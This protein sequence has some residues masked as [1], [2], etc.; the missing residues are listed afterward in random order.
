MHGSPVT[1]FTYF[2]HF[3]KTFLKNVSVSSFNYLPSSAHV[4]YNFSTMLPSKN[5]RYPFERLILP[6]EMR[7]LQMLF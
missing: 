6:R 5:S 3:Y 7:Q 2:H 1:F 4:G